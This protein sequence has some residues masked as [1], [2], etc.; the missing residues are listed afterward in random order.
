MGNMDEKCEPKRVFALK[1]HIILNSVNLFYLKVGALSE[2][3]NFYNVLSKNIRLNIN[4]QS[5][6]TQTFRSD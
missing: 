3:N 6:L 5:V 2:K 1:Q 4:S